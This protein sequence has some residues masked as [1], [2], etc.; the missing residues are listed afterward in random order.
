MNQKRT[1]VFI[2]G[3]NWYHNCKKVITPK[4]IDF[5]KLVNYI[6]NHFNLNILGIRYY[7]SIPDISE[8]ALR[9]HKHMEFLKDLE[10][11]GFKVLQES[12]KKPLQKKF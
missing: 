7:N 1:L 8:N 11:Q 3:N 6:S 9:Y 2:D 12:F 5:K 10:N 4:D